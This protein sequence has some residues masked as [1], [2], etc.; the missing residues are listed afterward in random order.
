MDLKNELTK[1]VSDL[2]V[3]IEEKIKEEIECRI[4][5]F[6]SKQDQEEKW[7][8]K[9]EAKL[10]LGYNSDT[11]LQRLRDFDQIVYTYVS[12]R[13]ILYSRSS[14]LEYLKLKKGISFE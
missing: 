4:S 14:I 5:Q 10:L 6:T 13:K 12:P 1:L 8:S 7:I 11:S 3:S 2:V 9:K